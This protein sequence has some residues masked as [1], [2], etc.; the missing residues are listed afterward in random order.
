MIVQPDFPEHW[1]SRR[2]VEIT[3][4]E[5]AI[6]AVIRLWAH[7]QHNRRWVFPNM[8]PA[9]LASI[10]RWND[11]KPPCHV[12]LTQA[13]FVDKLTPKGYAAHQWNEHNAQLIQKWDAGGKGGR[14]A[15]TENINDDGQNEKP[16]DN[17]PIT[18]TEPDKTRPVQIKPELVEETKP[19]RTPPCAPPLAGNKAASTPGG[20]GLDSSKMKMDMGGIGRIAHDI[21]TSK[22]A[23]PF[24]EP[25]LGQVEGYLLFCFQGADKYAKPF[26]KAMTK[27]GW[28]DKQG[29]LVQDWQAMAKAYAASAAMKARGIGAP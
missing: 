12:A 28:R 1:K 4:D 20:S 21:A 16:T 5:S 22:S 17:R 27:A 9:Q 7:C 10:C 23:P 11:R 15:K 25:S 3:G 6:V 13:G 8:T 14:P 26:L 24:Q 29:K 18:G 19:N 2:L